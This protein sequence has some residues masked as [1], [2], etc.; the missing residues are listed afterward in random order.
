MDSALGWIGQIASW[1]GQFFPHWQ[2]VQ[3]TQ[4]GVKMRAFRLRDV[5]L[6]RPHTMTVVA[7]SPGLHTFWPFATALLIYPTARQATDLRPQ[8]FVTKDDKTV[9][10]GGLI[11]YEIGDIEAILASTFDPDD[12]I[13]DIALT[14]VHDV[15]SQLTWDDLKSRQRDGSLDRDLRREA[16]KDLGRYGVTVLKMTLTDLAPCRVIKLANSMSNTVGV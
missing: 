1:F 13:K 11:V 6:F 8:V 9:L 3:T 12:T 10:V 14:A 16:K 5:F 15:C 2:I 7:L 4:G